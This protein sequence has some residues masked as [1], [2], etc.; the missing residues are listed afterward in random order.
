[1][2][3]SKDYLDLPITISYFVTNSKTTKEVV[4][5]NSNIDEVLE[6]LQSNRIKGINLETK[7]HNIKIG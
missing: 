4:I 1:M 6:A 7:I 5:K 2:A 3:R